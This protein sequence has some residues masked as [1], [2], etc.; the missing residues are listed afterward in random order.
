LVTNDIPFDIR[1]I[2]GYLSSFGLGVLV[3]SAAWF[4]TRSNYKEERKKNDV[5]HRENKADFEKRVD[6]YEQLT[7]ENIKAL[8]SM[9]EVVET[10]SDALKGGHESLHI[11][12]SQEASRIRD[13]VTHTVKELKQ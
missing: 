7:T 3:L 13:H 9:A 8:M 2:V 1:S 5:L 11:T 4:E 12:V 10:L 6:K